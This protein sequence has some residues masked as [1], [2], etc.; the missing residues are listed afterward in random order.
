MF[1][2][3]GDAARAS[4]ATRIV[5]IWTAGLRSYNDSNAPLQAAWCGA[6]WARAAELL[7]HTPGS[8][9]TAGD[10]D[11]F[12]T[13]ITRVTL[14]LIF[15]GSRSNGNWELSM[16]DAMLGFSVFLE[17]SALFEH[18]VA[19]WRQ[20]T[21]AYFYNFAADGTSHKPFPPGREGASWYNQ[22]VFDASTNG[23]CQE[24]CRDF[25]HM[26]MGLGACLGAAATARAAG[27]DLFAEE[28]PRLTG[29][30]EFAAGWLL[31]GGS[32]Q[33]PVLCSGA[34]LKLALVPTFEVGFRELS[35]RL[36]ARMPNT[37][38]QLQINVRPHANPDG[39]C[40]EWET[41]THG[42]PLQ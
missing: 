15:P 4:L 33:S 28:A 29:A 11:A 20:R 12:T 2:V 10:T 34:P 14:P 23:V 19:F 9:W 7:R 17:D 42:A 25:G 37:A 39:L 5:R 13:M 31:R 3:S 6:K 38:Q 30:M 40:S 26:Q 16:L 22:T 8:G 24:T 1:A 36:G 18:A 35:V 27:V 41:L 21:P 32:P